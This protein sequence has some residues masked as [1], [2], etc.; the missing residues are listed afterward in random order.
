MAKIQTI[1]GLK[2]RKV[3]S[4]EAWLKARK[5]LL[6]EEKKFTKLRDALS[7]QRRDLPWEKIEKQYVFDSPEG[8]QTLAELFDGKSQLLVWHFMFGPQWKEGCSHCSFC[9]DTFNANIAHL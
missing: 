7:K 2:T 5:E 3:V 1:S 9:A 4:H 6:K 8:K